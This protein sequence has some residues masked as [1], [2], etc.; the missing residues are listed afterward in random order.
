MNSN[1]SK[2]LLFFSLFATVFLWNGCSDDP[3]SDN[4]GSGDTPTAKGPAFQEFYFKHANNHTILNGNIICD[5]AEDGTISNSS[6]IDTKIL[7]CRNIM[8]TPTFKVN[9]GN[10]VYVDNIEQVSGESSHN[11]TSPVFYKV[12]DEKGNI[13][14][15]VVTLKFG[16][17][18]LPI[19]SIQTQGGRDIT[20]KDNWLTAT[21]SIE[22]DEEFEDLEEME[23]QVAGR[24]NSTW[25]YAKKPYK[26]K[27]GSK[28]EI[29]GMPKHKRWVL[30][31]NYIDKTMLRNDVSFYL[32][33]QTSLAWTPRGYHVEL[34]LNGEHKG[35]YYLC[36][37]IKIDKN[38]VNIT[39]MDAESGDITGGYLMEMDTYHPDADETRFY[40]KYKYGSGN[41]IPV[42]IKDP[43]AEDLSYDQLNYIRGY[44]HDF[45]DALFGAEWLDKE[46]G[47]KNYIDIYSFIDI[48]L[49][50]ELIHHSEWGHPKS[51]YLHKDVGG[52]LVSGPMWDYDW[53]T[54]TK[55][56]GWYC[57]DM[58]WYKQMF[59]DP[60][61][62]AMLKER[63]TELYPK[64]YSAIDYMQEMKSKLS[65]SAEKNYAIWDPGMSGSP[66]GEGSM[67]YEQSVDKIIDRFTERIKW[68]DKEIK[69][70]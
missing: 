44:F 14:E 24:G 26:L 20:S 69:R 62:V 54:F 61:F 22:G 8:L 25:N 40:S 33:K 5:I 45:E 60:E 30:L 1:I 38:R 53:T 16:T 46:K 70:L 37:Q 67:T 3:T 35:N 59:Q 66:N 7:A 18:G 42:K 10:K 15:Y 32:G 56:T 57:R 28:T 36:E 34:I 64:F 41:L 49:I 68:L 11:F 17:T 51:S 9:N 19:V 4:S 52:K 27:F 63:W 65:A 43:E 58:L 13:A 50:S 2:V 55:R 47:Y 39:E 21:I 6:D 48:Y 31:A 12:A 23:V 29:L